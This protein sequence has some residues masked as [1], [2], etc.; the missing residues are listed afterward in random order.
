MVFMFHSY[1]SAFE[2]ETILFCVYSMHGR[3]VCVPG[4]AYQCEW[5]PEVSHGYCSLCTIQRST[6]DIV[7]YALSTF[8]LF[9]YL[10]RGLLLPWGVFIKLG[11]LTTKPQRFTGLCLLNSGII[12][13]HYHIWIK[14]KWVLVIELWF[15]CS[16]SIQFT[17]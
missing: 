11:W 15:S 13:I 8:V 16:H 10:R 2:V 1:S 9:V 5:K 6:M 3:R 14:K 7:F 12:S 17:N 4:Y